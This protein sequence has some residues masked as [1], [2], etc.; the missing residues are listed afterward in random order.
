METIKFEAN[1]PQQICLKFAKGLPVEGNYG[2]QVLF[3]LVDG[4]RMYLSPEAAE[5][6]AGQA[7]GVPFMMCKK[8]TGKLVRWIIGDAE[9]APTAATPRLAAAAA[10][11]PPRAAEE[12]VFDDESGQMVRLSSF[13]SPSRMPPP[14]AAV[15]PSAGPSLDARGVAPERSPAADSMMGSL[16]A[17]ISAVLNAEEYAKR[18]GRPIEF[19]AED[20]R[21]MAITVFIQK[22]KGGGY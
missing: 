18:I 12:W 19:S 2:P 11:M 4:R 16:H 6:L 3:T 9:A 20:I 15:L 1:V 7:Q 22:T 21:A 10:T 13:P 14:S 5:R 17:A 8:Q